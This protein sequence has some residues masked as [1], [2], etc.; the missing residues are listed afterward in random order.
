MKPTSRP[1]FTL[2]LC[3]FLSACSTSRAVPIDD[4]A[5]NSTS[6]LDQE[7]YSNATQLLSPR[8]SGPR[9]FYA[10]AHRVLMCYGVRDA[11][12]HGANALEID[13]QPWKDRW[14]ADHDGTL[15]SKGDSVEA[16]FRT[17]AAE[18]RAG[19]NLVFV[20]LDIKNPDWCDRNWRTCNIEALRNLARRILQPAGIRVLYGFYN[21]HGRAFDII[22]GSLN[23]YEALSLDDNAGYARNVFLRRGPSDIKKRVLT[24]GLFFPSISFGK[25]LGNG[26]EICP[27]LRR[28]AES[29]MF[30]KVFGWTITK[31]QK[32][33]AELLMSQAKVDGLIYGFMQ[34]HY[35]DHKDTRLSL[36]F[37]TTWIQDHPDDHYLAT[38]RDIPW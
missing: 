20:W 24:R 15:T 38:V 19:K 2:F 3:V 35:Y 14:Y 5:S 21:P 25:C 32:T 34:T 1:F 13:V 16:M 7:E 33:Q 11:L 28:A 22:R 31:F 10:I 26:Y 30:G 6:I 29:K 12:W 27:Q 8:G 4:F 23:K 17:A 9:P 36:A 37:L 18:R